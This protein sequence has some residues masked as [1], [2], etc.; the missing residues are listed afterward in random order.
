MI[1]KLYE[2]SVLLKF[3]LG[4]TCTVVVSNKTAPPTC[5]CKCISFLLL[6]GFLFY[7]V[8]TTPFS[9]ILPSLGIL[10][11]FSLLALTSSL[12]TD[13]THLPLP[14]LVLGGLVAFLYFVCSFQIRWT[15]RYCTF[16]CA[17]LWR[18]PHA[19]LN[20]LSHIHSYTFSLL[21]IP[22]FVVQILLLFLGLFSVVL[23]LGWRK[24]LTFLWPTYHAGWLPWLQSYN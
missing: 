24:D 10:V 22:L 19:S 9:S 3:F 13:H 7:Q 14:S 8:Y 21:S 20:L 11:L 15:L 18:L 23:L 4:T 5:M 1:A 17:K 2:S 12:D 16:D 6:Q